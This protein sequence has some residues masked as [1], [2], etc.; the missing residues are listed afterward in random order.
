MASS[1]YLA[2][3][4]TYR[5]LCLDLA[6]PNISAEDRLLVEES[7]A[8]NQSI[9]T[10]LERAEK[11]QHALE[12]VDTSE[13]WILGADMFGILTYYRK[14]ED[15]PNSIIVKIHGTMDNLPLFEQ[16]A[17]MHEIDLFQEWVPFCTESRLIDKAGQAE[18]FW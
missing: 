5:K 17:V 13:N 7:L 1:R 2:A 11:I 9:Q 18:V 12:F 3:R 16:L 4:E 6:E 10:M 14:C 8:S 15:D